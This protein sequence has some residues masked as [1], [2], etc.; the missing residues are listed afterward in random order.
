[1]CQPGGWPDKEGVKEMSK[2]TAA[3]MGR[4]DFFRKAGLGVGA[5][6]AAAV[7]LSVSSAQAATPNKSADKGAGY[8]ETDHVKKFYE[9]AKF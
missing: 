8:R 2:K 5:A 3:K 9:L 7:G 1:M 6:G 4:R